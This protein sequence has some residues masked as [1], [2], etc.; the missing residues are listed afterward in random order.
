[1]LKHF[2]VKKVKKKNLRFVG[3]LEHFC[4]VQNKELSKQET[5]LSENSQVS[6]QLHTLIII[7]I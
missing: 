3:T 5:Q 2:N 6:S 7:M 1:M 4:L